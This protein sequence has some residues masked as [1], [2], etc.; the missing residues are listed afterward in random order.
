MR[1]GLIPITFAAVCAALAGACGGASDREIRE[2]QS[3]GYRGDFAVIYSETLAAVRDLYPE[4]VEDARAGVIRTAWHAVHVQQGTDDNE[5]QSTNPGSPRSGLQTTNRRRQ[6]FFIRFDVH[7]VGGR[8]WRVRVDG[9]ASS[10]KAGEVPSPMRGSEIPHWL[11]GRVNAL[12]V[13]VHQ[14]L[15]KYAV[16]LKLGPEPAAGPAAVKPL[17]QARFGKL[18]AGA[19]RVI[20][21]VERAAG[22]R[23]VARLRTFMADEFTYSSGDAPSADTAIVVW[24]ADPSILTELTRAVGAGCASEQASGQVVCPAAAAGDPGFAGY[25]VAFQAAGG[26]WTMVAFLAGD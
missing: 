24:R 6:E 14:R 26:S 8:P 7:V 21:E 2:A 16:G 1:T 15:K 5:N 20:A 23:D 22:A 3:S 17:D 12:E 10:W 18:P 25:R 11:E 4:L 13:A 19:A 9:E